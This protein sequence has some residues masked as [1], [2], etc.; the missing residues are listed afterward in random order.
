MEEPPRKF[1]RLAPGR[2][3]RLKHAYIIKC[4]QVIKNEAGEVVELHCTYDPDSKSGG[5]AS[6]RKVKGTSHWVEA[7]QALPVQVRIYEH[8]F[9][10]ENPEAAGGFIA[11]INPDSIETVLPHCKAPTMKNTF[12]SKIILFDEYSMIFDSTALMISFRNF[13]VCW[14]L[15]RYRNKRKGSGRGDQRQRDRKNPGRPIA[16]AAHKDRKAHV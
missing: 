10:S 3:I 7:T 5:P 9:R 8:L 4:E 1:F 2:E 11:D 16:A 6:N 15:E 14:Q 13:R 12:Y